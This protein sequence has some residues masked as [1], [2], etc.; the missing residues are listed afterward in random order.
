MQALRCQ[1][2]DAAMLVPA[3]RSWDGCRSTGP[4]LVG[5]VSAALAN[6]TA[7][8]LSSRWADKAVVTI[9]LA[10]K[11]GRCQ[12]CRLSSPLPSIQL[13]GHC[14][15]EEDTLAPMLSGALP[16]SLGQQQPGGFS[17]GGAADGSS[18]QQQRSY[19]STYGSELSQQEHELLVYQQQQQQQHAALL[20][21]QQQQAAAVAV[22]SQQAFSQLGG[23]P[24]SSPQLDGA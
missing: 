23:L 10:V 13:A 21:L 8:A 3:G 12:P 7:L 19:G 17:L 15:Q 2:S 5:P 16:G 9:R 6:L 11:G 22:A 18:G 24:A 20:A 14:M 4:P 1:S